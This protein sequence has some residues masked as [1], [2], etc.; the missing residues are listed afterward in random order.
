M[1]R[2]A[3]WPGPRAW[4]YA[5]PGHECPERFLI[6]SVLGLGSGLAQRSERPAEDRR[7]SGASGFGSQFVG[8]FHNEPSFR[9]GMTKIEFRLTRERMKS[10]S[11][12][13][14]LVTK[15]V[16]EVGRSGLDER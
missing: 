14:I 8:V 4:K 12:R 2:G 1:L 16:R 15:T 10:E 9:R 11:V 5:A 13:C 3:T 7:E 6:S